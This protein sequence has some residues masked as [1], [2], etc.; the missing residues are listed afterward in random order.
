V[1]QPGTSEPHHSAPSTSPGAFAVIIGAST[2]DAAVL[3]EVQWMAKEAGLP[4]TV[5]MVGPTTP[6]LRTLAA[7]QADQ[8]ERL[9]GRLGVR[10]VSVAPGDATAR[11]ID[12]W[13]SH[14]PTRIFFQRAKILALGCR[15]RRKVY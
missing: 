4:L 13:D 9:A 11:I 7:T 8:I 14:P 5:Y 15:H 1:N 3:R 12:D 2:V 6:W 10:V